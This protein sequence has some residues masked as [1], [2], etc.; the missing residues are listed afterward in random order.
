MLHHRTEQR[1][2]QPFSAFLFCTGGAFLAVVLALA[3]AN[4]FAAVTF[5]VHAQGAVVIT[6]AS[7][8]IGEHAAATLAAATNL[9]VFAGVRSQADADRLAAAYPR[10]RTLFIDVT[11]HASIAA[12]VSTVTS[13]PELPLVALVNN[14]GVQRDLPLELQSSA[15]DRFTFDVNVFGVLD[16]TRAFL[17]ALRQAGNGARIVNVGSLSGLVAGAGSA[18]YSASKHAVEG[19][20]DSLRREVQALGVSVSLLE[21]GYVR[22]EMG[23]KQHAAVDDRYGVR[24]DE[25]ALYSAVFEGF[26]AEDHR[27]SLP[28]NAA[29]ASAT[30][31][32]ILHA[33]TSPRPRTRYPVAKAGV[34]PAWLVAAVDRLLPDRVMDLLV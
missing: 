1:L 13:N 19:L 5:D 31:A 6:G 26:L 32:A 30:T 16:V 34:F 27:L 10:L 14:A 2:Q 3:L 12:A 20:T 17:P 18:T 25:Y 23:G 15:A 33:L 11:S 28:E 24:P 7:S 29:P 8:G 4:L 21:P 22:S 9:T